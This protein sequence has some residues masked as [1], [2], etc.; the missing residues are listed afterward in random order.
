MNRL[1]RMWG[2]MT[3]RQAFENQ[4]MTASS[5]AGWETI[6]GGNRSDPGSNVDWSRLAGDFSMNGVVSVATNW[7]ARTLPESPAMLT[8]QGADDSPEE[9]RQHPCL[10]LIGNPNPY[11]SGDAL[12]AATVSD[13]I[14]NGNAYWRI[15]R[16]A[17]GRG[18]AAQL[19]YIPQSRM[20]PK[21]GGSTSNFVD[22]YEYKVEGRTEY[23]D[24]E[25]VVHFRNGLDPL[26]FGLTG[27]SPLLAL[28]RQIVV[29]NLGANFEAS[30]LKNHGVPGLFV[31][32][33]ATTTPITIEE[34]RR[35]KDYLAEATTGDHVGEP[36][37]GMAGSTMT[38]FGFSP[39]QLTL[40][41]VLDRPE[42]LV[43]AA[44]GISPMVVGLMVGLE[45]S[46][47]SNMSEAQQAAYEKCVIPTKSAFAW[48]LTQQLLWREFERPGSG[49]KVAYDYGAVQCLQE[50]EDKR[51]LRYK[52]LADSGVYSVNEARAALGL[53]EIAGNPAYD[54]PLPLQARVAMMS[55]AKPAPEPK[56]PLEGEEPPDEAREN[57]AAGILSAYA[58]GILGIER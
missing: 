28:R 3:G 36:L 57:G 55:P 22:H 31:A 9:I 43:C 10:D 44:I 7:L 26:T 53:E 39:E 30:V 49:L 48:T 34:A 18:S 23:V 6:L 4:R 32:P 27:M 41:S 56:A 46:T 42:A 15:M 14:V 40:K 37:V 58:R 51:A 33:S 1:Q 29:L 54:E 35:W 50:D 8:R 45:H 13:Y 19:W 20:V 21:T 5:S 52:G 16:N 17:G 2:R 11:H 47:Y 12:M 24:P 25:D 38:A